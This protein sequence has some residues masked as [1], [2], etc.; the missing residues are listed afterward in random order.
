LKS[1]KKLYKRVKLSPKEKDLNL[2]KD[3]ENSKKKLKFFK[4]K[5]LP[6]KNSLW[7]KLKKKKLRLN[8]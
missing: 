1:L 5:K 8:S 4:D 3:K 6:L 7:L 2:W